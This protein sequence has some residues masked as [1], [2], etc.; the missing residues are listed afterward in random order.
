MEYFHLSNVYDHE[1]F[2]YTPAFDLTDVIC[3]GSDE[4]ETLELIEQ[5]HLRYETEAQRCA[6]GKLPT[7]QST[8]LKG[9]LS[10][11][12]KN[13]WRYRSIKVCQED[14]KRY[15]PEN[16]L[17]ILGKPKKGSSSRGSCNLASEDIVTKCKAP[18]NDETT[19]IGMAQGDV[20][21]SVEEDNAAQDISLFKGGLSDVPVKRKMGAAH[22]MVLR[23]DSYI[24]Y[25]H[26][27]SLQSEV[28]SLKRR[29]ENRRQNDSRNSKRARWIDEALTSPTPRTR[30]RGARRSKKLLVH[31]QQQF[32][33]SPSQAYISISI[34]QTMR[35]A[36]VE[37]WLHDSQSS[38]CKIP[39][40][41]LSGIV[42]PEVKQR[43]RSH[44]LKISKI[45]N[46]D[47]F[48][49]NVSNLSVSSLESPVTASSEQRFYHMDETSRSCVDNELDEDKLSKCKP[50]LTSSCVG[51]GSLF[52]N[53]RD[54]IDIPMCTNKKFTPHTESLAPCYV[55]NQNFTTESTEYDSSS[56]GLEKFLFKR[57]RKHRISKLESEYSKT[58]KK[59]RKLHEKD[60]SLASDNLLEQKNRSCDATRQKSFPL[61]IFNVLKSKDIADHDLV[62]RN[63]LRKSPSLECENCLVDVS[64][65]RQE[66]TKTSPSIKKAFHKNSLPCKSSFQKTL[67]SEAS[68]RSRS[69]P[70]PKRIVS[71]YTH[72][73][74]QTHLSQSSTK[75][76]FSSQQ[77]SS[78]N[79]MFQNVQRR[80]NLFA[81]LLPQK[82]KQNNSQTQLLS[83]R[84]S[85]SEYQL[86]CSS[87]PEAFLSDSSEVIVSIID[88][89]VFQ[90][91]QAPATTE[92]SKTK[93]LSL[94]SSN[95]P[96]SITCSTPHAPLATQNHMP[97][98]ELSRADRCGSVTSESLQK[99]FNN[100]LSALKLLTKEPILPML[101]DAEKNETRDSTY[102]C[103]Q[104]ENKVDQTN[105]RGIPQPELS[106]L[107]ERNKE[108]SLST[109]IPFSQKEEFTSFLTKSNAK[110]TLNSKSK[111][112]RLLQP[113]NQIEDTFKSFKNTAITGIADSSKSDNAD[114]SLQSPWITEIPAVFPACYDNQSDIQ[115]LTSD[116]I[117]DVDSAS[118]ILT[119]DNSPKVEPSIENM[120]DGRR[121]ESPQGEAEKMQL[122]QV[123]PFQ[124]PQAAHQDLGQTVYESATRNPW[125][126]VFTKPSS[127]TLSK[128]LSLGDLDLEDSPSE[129]TAK[130]RF[131]FDAVTQPADVDWQKNDLKILTAAK[132]C[133][134]NDSAEKQPPSLFSITRGSQESSSQ[135]VSAM[136]EAFIAADQNIDR[137]ITHSNQAQTRYLDLPSLTHVSIDEIPEFDVDAV[138]GDMGEFLEDWTVEAELNKINYP[139]Q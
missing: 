122:S 4:G 84:R 128:Q 127:K 76:D 100:K 115:T 58:R 136:A 8:I 92:T 56:R 23:R 90:L 101:I 89:S 118:L 131:S 110:E 61:N 138:L 69:E 42:S 11:S 96:L 113:S 48:K 37:N 121:S 19:R 98:I 105:I 21:I 91:S 130:L 119:T 35:H 9:P 31:S 18:D 43:K 49:S 81:D 62:S 133:E 137:D 46:Y 66:E 36:E 50:D 70:I 45:P 126:S 7:L 65:T 51:N 47:K 116:F 38:G 87:T 64:D 59:R 16:S 67:Q 1:P 134:E 71:S 111:D 103:D 20:I 44:A 60:E 129:Q 57:K 13:P 24:V 104:S 40:E 94:N 72:S 85:S 97:Q 114:S 53:E 52:A 25:T 125:Q 74:S 2:H 68:R 135:N 5:K 26:S 132:K 32:H 54:Q 29:R 22:D 78:G 99:K 106:N 10:P 109:L 80:Q 93:I 86:D 3:E 77:Q 28:K 83:S 33:V 88:D 79:N 55:K 124:T 75:L 108:D 82:S 14:K 120:Q 6:N 123:D 15:K 73:C 12:W 17:F 39:I 117:T 102:R 139:K 34:P 95:S 27:K 107:E 112:Y 63:Q 41:T 30:P